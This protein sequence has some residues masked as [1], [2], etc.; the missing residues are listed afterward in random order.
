LA[1]RV[2]SSSM[3]LSP[4]IMW[5]GIKKKKTHKSIKRGTF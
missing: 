2:V 1:E 4:K 3:Q 5:L